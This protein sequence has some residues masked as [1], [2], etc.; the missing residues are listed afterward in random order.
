MNKF[1]FFFIIFFLSNTCIFCIKLPLLYSDDGLIDNI[2]KNNNK[3][4]SGKKLRSLIKQKLDSY[5]Y[6]YHVLHTEIR[7]GVPPQCFNVAYDTGSP[8]LILGLHNTNSKFTK[9]F[10]FSQSET[11]KSAVNSFYA[12]SYRYGVIQAREVSDYLKLS[13]DLKSKFMLSFLVTWNTTE[14]YEFEGILGLGNYYPKRDEDNSFDERFSYIHNLFNN[15]LIKKKL[16][17]HEYKNRTHGYLY[18]GEIPSSMGYNYYK[19]TV[20]PFIAYINKWH[21]ESRSFALS[22][23][24]NFTQ[25]H[26]PLA[27]D[28]AYVDIRGPF[29]EANAILS[30]INDVSGGKCHYISEEIENEHKYIRL[31]CDYDLEIKNVPDVIYYLKGFELRL[32]NIDLFRVVL[33][34]GKKKYMSKIVGDSRYNYWNLGEPILKN[35]NMVFNYEDN[36]VG[37]YPNE[38]LSEGSWT[39]T[40]ILGIVFIVIGVM[41]IYIIC[42]RKKIFARVRSKDI[43]KFSKGEMLNPGSQIGVIIE[44]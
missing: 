8:Y 18:I 26:S 7:I 13:D 28:T 12:L 23:G 40:I 20:A 33:I 17:G 39:M 3:D 41:A 5:D 11:F 1:F 19:C 37:F 24:V 34:D 21:C 14:K 44:S 6:I 31:V 25:F 16:F 35:Y 2:Y 32:R 29:Y 43:E 4:L 30:E 36:T 10:N 22:N 38:N 42:N 27:F 9:S 15:G